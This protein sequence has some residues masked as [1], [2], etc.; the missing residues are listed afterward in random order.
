MN[1]K[2]KIGFI[3]RTLEEIYPKCE[4]NTCVHEWWE[5]MELCDVSLETG[6]GE[7]N[8]DTKKDE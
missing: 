4:Y 3:I 2:E 7:G 8:N 5:S 1:K 6:D